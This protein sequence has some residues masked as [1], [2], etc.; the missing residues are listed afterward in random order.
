[1]L[2]SS[3][4]S[5]HA[6]RL[7]PQMNRGPMPPVRPTTLFALLALAGVPALA[8]TNP[9]NPETVKSTLEQIFSMATLGA[10]TIKDQGAEVTQAGA[11]FLVRLPLAGFSAPPDAAINTVVR[12]N[13]NGLLDIT[14]MTFPSAGTIDTALS[15]G[16]GSQVT[17]SIGQQTITAKVDPTLT[18]RSSY[19]ADLRQVRLQSEHGDQQGEQ[20]IDRYLLDGAVSAD[21]AGLLTLA[22]QGSGT[23]FKFAGHGPNGI[24][25]DATVRALAGHFSVEGLN[26]AQGTRLL[27]AVRHIAAVE[28]ST[29]DEPGASEEQREAVRAIL[30]AAIGLLGRVEAEETLEDV[31][32][33]VDG[34]AAAT[35]GTVDRLRLSVSGEALDQ[36]VSAQFGIVLDGMTSSALTA[37]NAV[38]IPHHVELKTAVAGLQSAPL[39]AL[40]RS[41]TEPDADPVALEAQAMTLL[42]DPQTRIG[43]EALSFDSGPL[44]VKATARAVTRANG[45]LGADIHIVGKGVDALLAQVNGKPNLQSVTPMI[46]M[47]KGMGRPEGDSLVWDIHL[48]DG[49]I[50][51]NGTPL[52]QPKPGKRR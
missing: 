41:A 1:M 48:G 52:G 14:S 15:G 40:L 36:R 10:V 47:A 6:Q 3:F 46:F 13:E 12:P 45:Q 11:D 32:F 27:A 34:G 17:Y 28:H 5:Q 18:A 16:S 39:I 38:F 2:Y 7:M 51:V 19:Q 37:E 44:L 50:T 24:G 26:R 4:A 35:D 21:A 9:P 29:D 30:D 25:A 31:H 43:I 20:T 23:G 8:Q 42:A 33:A 22:S 49:P